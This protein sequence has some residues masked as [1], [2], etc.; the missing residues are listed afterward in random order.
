MTTPWFMTQSD[1]SG[2]KTT[3]Q[4]NGVTVTAAN[5]DAQL[6][7][8]GALYLDMLGVTLGRIASEGFR[9]EIRL[10]NEPAAD[11][12][13]QRENKWLIRYEDTS[14]FKLYTFELGCA[15][16][17]DGTLLLPNTDKADMT[18]ANWVALKASFDGF[19]R[20]P[21]GNPVNMIDATYVGRNT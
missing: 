8:F 5:F 13:A 14:T 6:A 10:S 17:V 3:S 16:L 4:V 12:E 9:Y 7:A 21:A 11:S 19:A 20:S 1:F 15:D 2:E 18:H